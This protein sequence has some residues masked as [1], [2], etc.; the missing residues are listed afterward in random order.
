MSC[1][2][3]GI[4]LGEQHNTNSKKIKSKNLKNGYQE[5]LKKSRQEGSMVLI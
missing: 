4:E 3:P 5:F 1:K 2:I